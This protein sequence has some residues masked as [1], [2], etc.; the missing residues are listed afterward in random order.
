M[1]S[2]ASLFLMEQLVMILVFALAAAL[3]LRLF[4]RT[5]EISLETA[6][7]D[8]AVAIARNGAELLKAGAEAERIEKDLSSAPYAVQIE[9]ISVEIPG[10]TQA[11]VM[12]YYEN[13]EL[14]SLIVGYQE[15]DE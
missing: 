5:Q 13:E 4:V 14:F 8:E 7:R 6:R 12:V 15:V 1:R 11:E 10:L 2:K 9:E 3:C